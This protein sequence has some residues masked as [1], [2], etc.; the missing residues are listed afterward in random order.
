[1]RLKRASDSSTPRVCGSA[2]PDSPVPAPRATT[3]TPI[4]WQMRSTATTCSSVL[5][6]ATT[7]GSAR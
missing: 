6:R 7:S 3:G 1:M 5:G 4:W 2:P